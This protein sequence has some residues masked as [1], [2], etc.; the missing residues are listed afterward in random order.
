MTFDTIPGPKP[1]LLVGEKAVSC[2]THHGPYPATLF[3]VKQLVRLVVESAASDMTG[4]QAIVLACGSYMRAARE[5]SAVRQTNKRCRWASAQCHCSVLSAV[6][7]MIIM[8]VE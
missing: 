5:D 7:P 4:L 6:S 2:A 1:R 8:V 3:R